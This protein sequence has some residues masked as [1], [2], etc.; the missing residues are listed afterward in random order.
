[1]IIP[2]ELVCPDHNKVMRYSGVC[3]I[4]KQ[5]VINDKL[6]YTSDYYHVWKCPG[7]GRSVSR[8][9]EKNVG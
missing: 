4:M 7:C 3:P 5:V 2:D 6:D 1:M 9:K 8:K